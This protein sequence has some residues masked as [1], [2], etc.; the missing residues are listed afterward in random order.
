MIRS[1]QTITI[2]CLELSLEYGSTEAV[3][4]LSSLFSFMIALLSS[5]AS[6]RENCVS[7]WKNGEETEI[8]KREIIG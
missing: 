4:S 7:D 1:E 5:W 8:L 2:T 6:E 3:Q